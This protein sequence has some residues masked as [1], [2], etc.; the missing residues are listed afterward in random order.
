MATT[1]FGMDTPME[2]PDPGGRA[3]VFV[4][5]LDASEPVRAAMKNGS[6][7]VGFGNLDGTVLIYFENNRFNDH[8]LHKWENKVYKSYDRMVNLA[9]TVNK[10]NCDAASLVQVGFVKGREILVTDMDAL[11][12][13]LKRCDALDT[14]P[15][16]AE[17][18]D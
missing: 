5:S 18:H 3:G 10:L 15:E 8:G 11:M 13:W 16:N 7:M 4:P 17:I 12:G 2:R 14:A 6:G 1:V 9:P